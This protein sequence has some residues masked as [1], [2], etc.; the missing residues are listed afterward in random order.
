[1]NTKYKKIPQII[2][3]TQYISVKIADYTIKTNYMSIP[4][5]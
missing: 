1:M 4:L 2:M 3:K 5:L